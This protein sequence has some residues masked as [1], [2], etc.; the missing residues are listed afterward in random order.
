MA[1]VG[2]FQTTISIENPARRGEARALP[3][4]LVDTGSE[5][6]WVPRET[7]ES[8]AITPERAQQFM[9]ADGRILTRE[10]G[11]AIVHVGEWS[12]S[13]D[14]VFAEVGDLVLLGARSLEGLN[15]RVDPH[16]RQLVPS[17]PIVT[18]AA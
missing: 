14:V 18:A 15:L 9:V 7:L 11:F 16:R 4:T 3:E 17:G 6:T 8:L 5:F 12:T 10:V 13:D 2:T 1:G